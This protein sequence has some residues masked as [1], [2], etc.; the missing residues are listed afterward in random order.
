MILDVYIYAQGM[1]KV[2]LQLLV[3]E[4]ILVLLFILLFSIGTTVNLLLPHP[5]CNPYKMDSM[6]ISLQNSYVKILTAR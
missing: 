3:C 4:F 1:A 5:V 6:C 2:G